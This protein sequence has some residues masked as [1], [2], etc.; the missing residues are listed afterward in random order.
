VVLGLRGGTVGNQR[1]GSSYEGG[2]FEIAFLPSIST[3]A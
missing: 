2:S 1:P 3:A